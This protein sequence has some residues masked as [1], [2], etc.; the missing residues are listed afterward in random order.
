M[1]IKKEKW[2]EWNKKQR[3]NQDLK[4]RTKLVET[5]KT[6][7][8]VII[9]AKIK[10]EVEEKIIKICKH[11]L[12]EKWNKMIKQWKYLSSPTNVFRPIITVI[13]DK[14]KDRNQLRKC[15]QEAIFIRPAPLP[16]SPNSHFPPNPK[17]NRNFIC[18][19]LW[20]AENH[21]TDLS[22]ISVKLKGKQERIITMTIMM[23]T[24]L[25]Y[26]TQN[27]TLSIS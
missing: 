24:H 22:T 23:M 13:S 14:K 27:I 11:D 5:M 20:W 3:T 1:R 26:W 7:Y 16:H 9:S 15:L 10:M 4:K 2:I 8:D 6:N 18:L 21:F 12:E 25:L 17:C 19:L